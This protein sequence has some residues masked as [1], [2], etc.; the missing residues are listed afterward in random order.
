MIFE[1]H[2]HYDDE[3]FDE[4][5]EGLLQG[6][7]EHGIG[8]II[9][10]AANMQG[11]RNSVALA[12]QHPFV[13]A[14]V[15]VHPS[16]A[17]ELLIEENI[18]ELRKLA[19]EEKV[20]AIGEIGLDYHWETPERDIQKKAFELQLHMATEFD[21]P[22]IVHSRDAAKDTLDMIR[23]F[24]G[25][26]PQKRGVIHCFSYEKEMAQEYVKMGYHI[27]VGGVIT[28]KNGRKLR[29]V[30]ETIPMESILLE[31]DSPYLAPEP[32]RGH[33]NC[34]YYLP[35]VAEEIGRIKG[36]SPEE[37]IQITK[38]NAEHVFGIK[39]I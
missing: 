10:V 38:E 31:T 13:Y 34:S 39:A 11:S 9:N 37:V 21:L 20:L 15:G 4:D 16:D 6:M 24:P 36:L 14:A 25:M 8:T 28:F 2:A 18:A 7:A 30:V 19:L 35:L 23:N 29:E 5:R 3:A 27:G 33:R 17:E 22:I 1:T 26:G 12:A 32:H